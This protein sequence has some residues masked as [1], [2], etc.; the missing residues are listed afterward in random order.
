MHNFTMQSY[1]AHHQKVN[2][3]TRP[4]KEGASTN[5]ES[6]L[7]DRLHTWQPNGLA[8]LPCQHDSTLEDQEDRYLL[9]SKLFLRFKSWSN[10]SYKQPIESS[11]VWNIIV[12]GYMKICNMKQFF[13]DFT[14]PRCPRN[15]RLKVNFFSSKGFTMKC[16]CKSTQRSAY[17]S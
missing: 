17:I 8:S 13:L 9:M 12:V 5:V 14:S 4:T 7:Q 2:P 1:G 10:Y 15:R 6:K 11:C 3:A 16:S